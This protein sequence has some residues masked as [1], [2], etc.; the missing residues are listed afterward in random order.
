MP[1]PIILSTSHGVAVSCIMFVAIFCLAFPSFS[2][3]SQLICFGVVLGEFVLLMGLQCEK[4]SMILRSCVLSIVRHFMVPCCVL[5]ISSCVSTRL[6]LK[7]TRLARSSSASTD[8]LCMIC[9]FIVVVWTPSWE[10]EAL[11]ICHISWWLVN[12]WVQYAFQMGKVC[13]PSVYIFQIL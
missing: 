3:L 8:S 7:L 1:Q 2:Y 4:T 13:F 11:V 10:C 6:V 5:M 9:C 12:S